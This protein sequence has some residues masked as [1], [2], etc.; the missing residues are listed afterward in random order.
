MSIDLKKN[1]IRIHRNTLKIL[2]YPKYI[3][4]LINPTKEL[5]VVMP[6]SKNDPLAHSVRLHQITENNCYEL[7]SKKLVISIKS[8]N[9]T[10]KEE[11]LYRLQGEY[12]KKYNLVQFS[13]NVSERG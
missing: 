2:G 9:N 5:I 1:R 13:M 12:Y 11:R 3:Q 6:G 10:F 4:M 8:I 7:F